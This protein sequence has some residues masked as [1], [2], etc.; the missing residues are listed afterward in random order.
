MTPRRNPLINCPLTATW[1]A[2]GGKWKLTIIYW[3]AEQPRHFAGLRRQLGDVSISVSQ[4]VLAQQLRELIAD[5]IVTRTR[6]GAVPAPVIYALTDYGNTVLPLVENARLWG[7]RHIERSR[8]TRPRG[9]R[10]SLDCMAIR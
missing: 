7:T 5:G 2:V 6:T 8:A 9:A 4:K 1:A 10:E 3:L